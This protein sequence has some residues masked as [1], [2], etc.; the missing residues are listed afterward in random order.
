MVVI[1]MHLFVSQGYK[2]VSHSTFISLVLLL[3]EKVAPFLIVNEFRS[4]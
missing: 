2:E 3:A 1:C 4:M